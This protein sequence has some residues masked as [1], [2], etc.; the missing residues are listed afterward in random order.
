MIDNNEELTKDQLGLYNTWE[1]K[2]ADHAAYVAKMDKENMESNLVET[3]AAK[4]MKDRCYDVKQK[5]KEPNPK[6][7]KVLII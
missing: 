7:K 3:M 6:E 5:K 4:K 1:T 2:R